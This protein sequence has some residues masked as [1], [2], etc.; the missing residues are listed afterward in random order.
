MT[1][2]KFDKELERAVETHGASIRDELRLPTSGRDF[3]ERLLLGFIWANPINA[4]NGP[5]DL[6]RLTD[7]MIA[8]FGTKPPARADASDDHHA[9]ILMATWYQMDRD[10]GRRPRSVRTL[11]RVASKSAT[12]NSDDA[13]VDRLRRKFRKSKSELLGNLTERQ[14]E[15]ELLQRR[16]LEEFET[17]LSILGIR[18]FSYD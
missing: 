5:T 6:Q 3:A 18:F 1:E 17:R 12:G 9:L 4:K 13:V 16:A 7:S 15:I 2:S 10:L 11:A 8:L 14:M